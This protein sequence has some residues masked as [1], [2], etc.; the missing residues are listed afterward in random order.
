MSRTVKFLSAA[1]ALVWTILA[2]IHTASA[3][4]RSGEMYF[5]DAPR[6][7]VGD[8]VSFT[9]FLITEKGAPLFD[10]AINFYLN[11]VYDTTLMTNQLGAVHYRPSRALDA[12]NYEVEA[13]YGGYQFDVPD[14]VRKRFEVSPAEIV[15]QTVPTLEGLE[16]LLDGQLIRTGPDGLVRVPVNSRGIYD[17]ELLP[18]IELLESRNAAFAQWFPNDYKMKTQVYVPGITWVQVGFEVTTPF[19]FTFF[20][21]EGNAIKPDRLESM[22]LR[23]SNGIVTEISPDEETWLNV[24][25]ILARLNGLDSATVAHSI[26]S[27][28][29]DGSEVVN[30]GQQRFIHSTGQAVRI[31]LLLYDVRF[32]GED[33]FLGTPNGTGLYLEMPDGET[34]FYPFD[35]DRS[36]TISDLARGEYFA[37]IEAQGG[38]GLR[39]PLVVSRSQEVRLPVISYLD[40]LLSIFLGSSLIF[41]LPLI[42]RRHR[43]IAFLTGRETHH[44]G[45]F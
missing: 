45:R 36:V 1:I 43:V 15:V 4:P 7:K 17:L 24:N 2:G 31:E 38:I 35:S 28:V 6:Y 5:L 16:L 40:V 22:T 26:Q 34:Q 27:V 39:F 3:G 19:T 12:G 44:Q 20:D 9:L 14:S 13:F 8:D 32:Y 42:G 10:Q 33:V 41:G 30:R 21:S 29:V 11:G 23:G 25:R 18:N 37:R